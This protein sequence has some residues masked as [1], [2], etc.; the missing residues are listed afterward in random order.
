MKGFDTHLFVHIP[1]TAGTSFRMA[2]ENLFGVERIA[3]DYSLRAPETSSCVREHYYTK[4]NLEALRELLIERRVALLGGH[5][6]YRRYSSI[7]PTHRVISFVRDPVSR[8]LS[9]YH[10]FSRHYGFTGA[11]TDFVRQS[12]NQ[13]LQATLLSGVPLREAAFVGVTEFYELS[14]KELERKLGWTL[15]V[16]RLNANPERERNG[17]PEDRASRSEVNLIKD[18]NRQD[19]DLYA[20]AVALMV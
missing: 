17:I 20:A 9:E 19:M 16:L 15:C 7:L 1:K 10:H 8:V 4:K 2:A 11:L 13:N 12:R 14:L 3:Y 5:F 18:L 6:S